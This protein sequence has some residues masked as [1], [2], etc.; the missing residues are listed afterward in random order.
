MD[1]FTKLYPFKLDSWQYNACEKIIIDNKNVLVTAHTGCGKTLVAESGIYSAIKNNKKIIYTSPIKSL[2]N[3]KFNEFRKKY[4]DISVGILTGDIKFNPMA[5]IIIMT[6]EILRNYLY[7]DD[8]DE[9]DINNDVESVVFDEVHYI[10][11]KDRGKVWEECIIMLP[12]HIKLIMLSASIDNPKQFCNWLSSIKTKETF[13]YQTDK[14]VIP[15]NHSVLIFGS[16]KKDKSS[17][18]NSY[19][20]KIITL[21]D[22]NKVFNDTVYNDIKIIKKRYQRITGS[23]FV[24][25]KGIIHKC[26]DVLNSK[27]L[28]PAIFFVFS[29]KK[30]DLY[31]ESVS[32]VLN[33]DSEQ[34][35]VKRIVNFYLHK[36]ENKYEELDQFKRYFPLWQKGIAVHNSGLVPVLK[37]IIEILFSKSLIKILFATETFAVG[38]NMPAK[39]VI[40]TGLDKFDSSTGKRFLK[41]HEYLQMGGRAGRRGIDTE[42]IVIHLYNLFDLPPLFELK[43]MMNGNT[44]KIISRFDLNFQ[45]ILKVILSNK[46]DISK[47]LC[48]SLLNK[49][50]LDQK[51]YIIKKLSKLLIPNYEKIDIFNKIFKIEFKLENTEFGF[52]NRQI[53]KYHNEINKLNKKLSIREKENYKKF[54]NSLFEKNKLENELKYYD[55]VINYELQKVLTYLKDYGYLKTDN[56]NEL[57][58]DVVTEKGI[59][60]SKISECNEILMTEMLFNGDFDYVTFEELIL[61]LTVFIENDDT[62]YNTENISYKFSEYL[63]ELKR[64][65][66]W[67]NDDLVKRKIYIPY[68]WE[69]NMELFDITYDWINGKAFHELDFPTFEG[70]FINDMIKISAISKTLE[71]VA[72]MAGK[73]ELAK[74]ASKIEK[75][76]MRDVISIESLYIE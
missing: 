18:I 19:N 72:T 5:Q 76:L 13:L 45:L 46:T 28:F 23:K 60:A 2:S 3:Q 17:I 54:S 21:M 37:E 59:I 74:N 22:E 27:K 56:I 69:I 26:I 14:R 41:T 12:Q 32:F 10:T 52:S 4:P 49:E 43:N 9:I 40:M 48:N 25:P 70:N 75:I 71:K 65:S 55:E 8:D 58:K 64:Y 11:D 53:K 7:K 6:T 39:A 57:S 24:K 30:C 16:N 66:Y 38:I 73:H 44:Q 20:K 15:L 1:D 67:V 33:D 35:E 68:C 42:G 34:K 61:L 29:R 36:L 47:I 51:Q 63:K 50:Y 31:A 62:K